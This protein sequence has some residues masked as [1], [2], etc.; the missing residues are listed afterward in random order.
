MPDLVTVTLGVVFRRLLY[1]M[2]M[3]TLVTVKC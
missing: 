1:K 2:S 3:I